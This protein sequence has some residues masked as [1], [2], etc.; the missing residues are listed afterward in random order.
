ML[1]NSYRKEDTH[2]FVTNLAHRLKKRYGHDGVFVDYRDLPIGEPWP[3]GLRRQLQACHVLL[4]VIGPKWGDARFSSGKNA[5]RLRLDDPE[6]WV[7]QE[8]CTA[9]KA[10]KKI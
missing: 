3:D 1:F 5:N 2:A 10:G 4:A 6:D 7:R 9:I 8:I